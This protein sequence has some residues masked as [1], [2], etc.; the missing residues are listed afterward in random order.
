M[1]DLFVLLLPLYQLLC[2][3]TLRLACLLLIS[4]NTCLPVHLLL[5]L[6]PLNMHQILLLC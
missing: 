5:L 1:P 3:Y 4:L 2:L 6:L